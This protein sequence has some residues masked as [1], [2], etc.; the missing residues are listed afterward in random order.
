MER[1][2]EALTLD[3]IVTINTR[4]CLDSF[5]LHD[6]GDNFLNRGS[7]EFILDAIHECYFGVEP[8]PTIPE[9]AAAV[10]WTI[11]ASHVFKDANKR[12]G[13]ET[14]RQI[15]ERNHYTWHPR[16]PFGK[17]RRLGQAKRR[18]AFLAPTLS[19]SEDSP[20]KD[21]IGAILSVA[22]GNMTNEEFC[23]WVK[24]RIGG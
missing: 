5:G 6:G 3:E 15:L 23:E 22:S 4:M 16:C 21:A 11:V 2:C 12:T 24:S 14:C 18:K 7:L 20:D 19:L 13:L 10:G 17:R 8:Y 1:T 9:K